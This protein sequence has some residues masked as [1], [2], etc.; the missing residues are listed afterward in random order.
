MRGTIVTIGGA[1]LVTE[2]NLPVPPGVGSL[3]SKWASEGKT[4]LYV[5][6]GE[7][8]LGAF[9][10]EDEIRGESGEAVTELHR[11]GIRV[12]MIT[13]DSKTDRKSVV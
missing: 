4:I 1:R 2:T 6:A 12:A 13:G 5:V 7:R 9:A 10:V 3:T 8:L 11:L